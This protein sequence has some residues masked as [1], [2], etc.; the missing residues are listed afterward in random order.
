MTEPAAHLE[1]VVRYYD[2]HPINEAQILE[3][4]RQQGIPLEGLSEDVL[5]PDSPFGS[6]RRARRPRKRWRDRGFPL[7][8]VASVRTRSP[9]L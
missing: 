5:N 9:D 4:L 2:T 7:S 3:K 6:G 8:P 1:S